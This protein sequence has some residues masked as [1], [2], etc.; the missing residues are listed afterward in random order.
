MQPKRRT[1]F[2]TASLLIVLMLIVIVSIQENR[3][4]VATYELIPSGFMNEDESIEIT[5]FPQSSV[6]SALLLNESVLGPD[7]IWV[8]DSSRWMDDTHF[9]RQIPVPTINVST[10]T[11]SL[12][13]FVVMGPIELNLRYHDWPYDISVSGST[14]ETL[15]ITRDVTPDDLIGEGLTWIDIGLNSTDCSVI[16]HLYFSISLEFTT[17]MFPVTIDLQRTNGDSLFDLQEFYS[18]FHTYDRPYVQLDDYEFYVSQ[19]NDT[20][21]LPAGVYALSVKW[22][23]YQHSFGNIIVNNESLSL[24][25][26]IKTVRLDV[27]SL[28]KIPGLAIFIERSSLEH[29]YQ[30]I[31]VADEPSFYFPSMVYM[32]ISVRGDIDGYY[33][34]HHFSFYVENYENQNITLFVSEN[35]IMVGNIAFTPGRFVMLIGLVSIFIL[36]TVISRK[37]LLTSSIYLPFLLL[38]IGNTLPTYSLYQIRNEMPHRIPIY[39]EYLV[40]DTVSPGILTS[41]SGIDGSAI[42][43]SDAGF[44][45]AFQIG[46]ISF[47]LLLVVFLTVIY[48]YLRKE[49]DP[50]TSNFPVFV[51]I[52][53]S[54]GSQTLFIIGVFLSTLD[55][56]TFSLGPGLVFTSL[57]LLTWIVL[58]ERQGKTIFQTN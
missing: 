24:E 4:P 35:W 53:C 34:P 6:S 15:E 22:V 56:F 8:E 32:S 30:E 33:W 41:I 26:G 27:E 7:S 36:T 9:Y 25:L 18:I 31:F 12:S 1:K 37:K 17:D 52:L 10:I 51:P 55:Y 14:G 42:I 39:S 49:Q 57:A 20:I 47:A 11:L 5:S 38:F 43:I 3:T 45:V 21:F 16:D 23:S 2:A 40:T 29:F 28:Q 48:E 19:V 58:Y 13:A 44:E 46:F 50:A 54:L